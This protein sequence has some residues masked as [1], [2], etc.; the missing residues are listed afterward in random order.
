MVSAR[1]LC[2]AADTTTEAAEW[3]GTLLVHDVLK[4]LLGLLEAHV[5]DGHRGLTGVLEV[6]TEIGSLGLAC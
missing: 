5:L 1:H 2:G 3:D 6:N 4:V